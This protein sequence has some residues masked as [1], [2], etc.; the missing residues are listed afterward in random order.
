MERKKIKVT[1]EIRE[2][3]MKDFKVQ[4]VTLTNYLNYKRNSKEAEM[5]REAALQRGGKLVTLKEEEV[6]QPV[7][8]I[9]ILDNKGN[10]RAVRTI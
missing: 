3:L 7:K 1:K 9:K 8:K 4:Y 10:V 2:S 6:E 5:I